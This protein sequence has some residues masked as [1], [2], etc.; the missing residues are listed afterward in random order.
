M[1]LRKWKTIW[2]KKRG[3]L[4]LTET[5]TGVFSYNLSDSPAKLCLTDAKDG[6][7]RFN[8][9]GLG[10]F[11]LPLNKPRSIVP[12]DLGFSNWGAFRAKVGGKKLRATML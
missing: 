7:F 11:S 10:L 8:S 5:F 2:K 9:H 4:R 6:F 12:F 3:F 1:V